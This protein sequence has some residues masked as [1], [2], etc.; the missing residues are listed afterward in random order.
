MQELFLAKSA[1]F[2]IGRSECPSSALYTYFILGDAL[3][4]SDSRE[5]RLFRMRSIAL[6]MLAEPG[7]KAG[8]WYS[9]VTKLDVSPN[10]EADDLLSLL[11]HIAAFN[12]A[13]DV[14][15]KVYGMVALLDDVFDEVAVPKVDYSKPL[16][17]VFEEFAYCMVR[18]TNT[19][20]PLELVLRSKADDLPSWVPDLRDPTA[21]SMTAWWSGVQ[22]PVPH[23]TEME[24]PESGDPGRLPV[25]AR[26]LARVVEV[27][28][29]I[30]TFDIGADADSQRTDYL[31]KWTAI[32]ADLDGQAGASSS[33]PVGYYAT[34][35]Q[36]L[37]PFLNYIRDRHTPLK[38]EDPRPK[39]PKR[40]FF[41][42]RDP[43]EKRPLRPQDVVRSRFDDQYDGA[44]L[45]FTECGLLGL[46]KGDVRPNDKVCQLAG[47]RYPFILRQVGRSDF[48]LVSI[49]DVYGL[50]SPDR[51]RFWRNEIVGEELTEIAL[52]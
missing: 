51:E 37:T 26:Y 9:K 20:W 33:S 14:R 38:K 11:L 5:R 6:E 40:S 19:L 47:G 35:L 52:V 29:R 10:E 32:T 7:A 48:R 8:W 23:D 49:T 18:T 36:K 17:R 27:Y 12:D 28:A 30:P 4:R 41:E 45:F 13:T 3:M 21:V 15:D 16:A 22:R 1:T 34:A 43:L 39:R 50:D 44:A 42:R 31:S 46:C 25:K 24:L 2:L